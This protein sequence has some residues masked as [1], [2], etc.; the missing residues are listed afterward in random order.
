MNCLLLYASA[1]ALVKSDNG[2]AVA[3]C[4]ESEQRETLPLPVLE[5]DDALVG[6]DADDRGRRHHSDETDHASRWCRHA[7]L[8]RSP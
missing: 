2:K 7:M 8:P 6:L 4:G 5:S 3:G 1:N